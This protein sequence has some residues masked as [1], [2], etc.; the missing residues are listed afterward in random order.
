MP[1]WPCDRRLPVEVLDEGGRGQ[2]PES[3]IPPEAV[4]EDLDVLR[5]LH[6]CFCHRFEAPVMRQISPWH[7][8]M[9]TCRSICLS[10]SWM[11]WRR[12]D[13]QPGI[14]RAVQAAAVSRAEGFRSDEARHFPRPHFFISPGRIAFLWI[15]RM[16]PE[17]I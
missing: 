5:D 10:D 17:S 12:A 4:V 3:G 11:A 14:F 6:S 9:G 16:A 2:I 8:S 15:R 13:K 7:I 1:P